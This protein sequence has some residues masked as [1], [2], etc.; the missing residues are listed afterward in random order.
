VVVVVVVMVVVVVV[1]AVLALLMRG[2]PCLVFL[3][4]NLELSSA[5]LPLLHSCIL[6]SLIQ[7]FVLSSIHSSFITPSLIFIFIHSFSPA[8][9]L[10]PAFTYSV[11]QS[12][13]Q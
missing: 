11:S 13:S 5:R 4:A 10:N 2:D 9:T 8:F 7:S 6:H 1:V 12:A 3:P